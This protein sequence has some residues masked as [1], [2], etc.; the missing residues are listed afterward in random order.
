LGGGRE[1][2]TPRLVL[3]EAERYEWAFRLRMPFR[4]GGVTVTHGRQAVIRVRIRLDDGREAW[5]YGAESL[6][7]KW[8][9]K[10][11]AVSDDANLDQL[12]RALE[13]ASE[14]YQAA[15]LHTA[16]GLYAVTYE[17]HRAACAAER[18]NPLV[19]GFGPALLDR[20]V[21]DA[22]CRAYG[23]S[24]YDAVRANLPGL[25]AA[26]TPDLAGFDLDRFLESLE[27]GSSIEARH[28][29]GLVDPITSADDS[30]RVDDGLPETLE[31]VVETYGNRWFKLKVGGDVGADLDRLARIAAVLD[32]SPGYR[33]TLDGNE[34]YE[35]A[36]AALALWRGIAAHPRLGRLA[37]TV[38]FIEQ[39][40]RRASALAAPVSALAAERRVLIDES[41]DGLDAFP[42]ARALGYAGVSS[43]MC[44]GFYKSL[45]NRA[46]CEAWGG[47]AF[48]SGEDL[49]TQPGLS[50]QQDLALA[51]LL[52]LTHVERNGH[53]FIRGFGGRPEAE[54]DAF[55]AAHP[56]LYR[57][58]AHDVCLRIEQGR[59][60]TSS[61]ACPGF[62]AAAFPDVSAQDAMQVAKWPLAPSP[63]GRGL[64]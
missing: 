38:A 49:T 40:I 46:R 57:R 60:A 20:A 23:I 14:A 64:G 13:L 12:R 44:K 33:V 5:G 41:D 58:C 39:P 29:V 28:T 35:D 31:E 21:L 17:A 32:R 16:F 9:D 10:D 51:S 63:S 11:P 7:A 55:L 52:G 47:G 3:R 53:H 8:F 25:T 62:G 34:Q 18:L 56:D 19:A 59:I 61:L 45:L 24:F 30:D 2:L 22:L 15:G 48:M 27:H 50:V 1:V 42:R 36:E 4:F 26:L 43:K 6:A 37:D 54:A